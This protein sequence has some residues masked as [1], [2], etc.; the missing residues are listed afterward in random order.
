[1]I[2]PEPVAPID[3]TDPGAKQI[4]EDIHPLGSTFTNEGTRI[5][6]IIDG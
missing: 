3:H 5:L 1:M 4:P 6:P 2:F